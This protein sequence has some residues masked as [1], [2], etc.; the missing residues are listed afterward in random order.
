MADL[1]ELAVH[2]RRVR[3][4]VQQERSQPSMTGR[5]VRLTAG[6]LAYA[7]LLQQACTLLGVPTELP[8]CSGIAR[9]VEILRIEAVLAGHGITT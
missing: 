9:N 5:H 3:T 8:D 1:Q 7:D 4:Q 6:R 2:L